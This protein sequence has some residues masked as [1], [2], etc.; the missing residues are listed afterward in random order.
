MKTEGSVQ[1]YK[2]L[3]SCFSA[4][5]KVHGNQDRDGNYI[6]SC[7]KC[8]TGRAQC[9][10][11]KG[12]N[13]RMHNQGDP[14]RSA[15]MKELNAWLKEE[16][17]KRGCHPDHRSPF[18]PGDIT[19][20]HDNLRRKGFDIWELQNFIVVLSAIHTGCRFDSYSE[21]Q[22]A[23]FTACQDHWVIK[24]WNHQELCPK[25]QRKNRQS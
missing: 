11:H 16:T 6:A 10:E 21:I 12:L 25:G 22:V 24:G 7:E 13:F 23:S 20:I 3:D 14:M 9:H 5:T 17:I 19:R 18:L 1:N 2:W 15:K 4:I 8:I